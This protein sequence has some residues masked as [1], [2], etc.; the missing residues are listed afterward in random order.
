MFFSFHKRD[1]RRDCGERKFEQTD[2]LRTDIQVVTDRTKG[3]TGRTDKM[4][5]ESINNSYS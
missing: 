4:V 5:Q 2:E 1:I 3:S